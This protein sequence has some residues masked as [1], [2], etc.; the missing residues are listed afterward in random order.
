VT[1]TLAGGTDNN[2]DLNDAYEIPVYATDWGTGESTHLDVAVVGGTDTAVTVDSTA[3]FTAQ[4]GDHTWIKVGQGPEAEYR[5]VTITNA[6]T[7]TIHDGALKF[8]YD[9]LIGAPVI[10]VKRSEHGIYIQGDDADIYDGEI[11]N[12]MGNGIRSSCDWPDQGR[13][14]IHHCRIHN[15]KNQA[16]GEGTPGDPHFYVVDHN[17]FWDNADPAG[18]YGG[19]DKRCAGILLAKSGNDALDPMTSYQQHIISHNVIRFKSQRVAGAL[20]GMTVAGIIPIFP[21]MAS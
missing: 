9:H 10:G 6:T 19:L 1:A 12:A 15:C 16:I 7:F 3:G 2:W 13:F 11:C 8:S 20:T 14:H 17:T 4:D 5:C 18:W 21:R